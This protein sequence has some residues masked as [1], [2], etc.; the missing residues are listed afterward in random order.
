MYHH[1]LLYY[2]MYL[3]LLTLIPQIVIVLYHIIYIHLN[4]FA[5]YLNNNIQSCN[6]CNSNKSNDLSQISLSYVFLT[7]FWNDFAIVWFWIATVSASNMSGSS[8]KQR[9]W[10]IN[11]EDFKKKLCKNIITYDKSNKNYI[12]FTW[13]TYISIRFKKLINLN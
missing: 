12:Y 9:N 7:F 2:N 1:Q 13:N 5:V 3:H 11:P 4:P 10:K 6:W 8:S